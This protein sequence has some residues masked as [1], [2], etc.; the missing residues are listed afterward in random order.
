MAQWGQWCPHAGDGLPWG[1]TKGTVINA[2]LYEALLI[3]GRSGV[4][5]STVAWEVSAQ[6]QAAEVAHCVIEGDFLDQA[7]PAPPGD[8]DR[9]RLTEANLA[10]MWRNYTSLGYRRLIYT[11]TVSILESDL[12]ARAMGGLPRIT[13]VLL[14]AGDEATH[15]RLEIRE[16]GS[17]LEAHLSRSWRMARR[18]DS[19]APPW[20]VRVP[21]D[22]RSVMSIAHEVIAASHWALS[23]E[24]GQR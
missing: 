9:T 11:N 2:Y 13:G 18:L 4:G 22:G 24:P 21:T 1:L 3:G 16:T 19:E 8:P 7:Y 15:G 17:Q 12:V 20:V 23:P 14:T 5:K 10:A 6:L